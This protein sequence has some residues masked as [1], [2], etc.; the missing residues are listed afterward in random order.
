MRY[1][2]MCEYEAL[3]TV[4]A[5]VLEQVPKKMPNKQEY[6]LVSKWYYQNGK[7]RKGK[8]EPLEYMQDYFKSIKELREIGAII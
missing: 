4:I 6:R 5:H 1:S 8:I 7:L 2:P 3:E